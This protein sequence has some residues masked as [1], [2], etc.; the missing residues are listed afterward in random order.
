MWEIRWKSPNCCAETQIQKP[1]RPLGRD[2]VSVKPEG[3]TGV[4]RCH[5]QDLQN[6]NVW[7]EGYQLW[8][9]EQMSAFPSSLE[10]GLHA[11][12]FRKYTSKGESEKEK[13]VFDSSQKGLIIKQF[14]EFTDQMGKER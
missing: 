9:K 3:R 14:E 1:Q 5:F 8:K 6:V 4:S 12:M 13:G 11:Q 10:V 7:I 2:N